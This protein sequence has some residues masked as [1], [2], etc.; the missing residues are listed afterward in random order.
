[1]E[2]LEEDV[3]LENQNPAFIVDFFVE[4]GNFFKNYGWYTLLAF[5]GVV[6]I[7]AKLRPYIERYLKQKEDAE[8]A[9]RYHKNPDVFSARLSAMEAARQMMQENLNKQAEEYKI[10]Q[11]QKEEQKRQE[12]LDRQVGANITGHKLG[13]SENPEGKK[14]FKP[15]YNPLMG[16]SGSNYRAPKRSACSGGGCG[17]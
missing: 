10:K 14:S 7:Y 11:Q 3:L 2:P 13:R 8:Y 16:G 5:I 9:A 12:W 15:E 4:V 1:M 17:K 6:Y